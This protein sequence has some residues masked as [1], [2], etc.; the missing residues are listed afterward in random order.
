M[1]FNPIDFSP[2]HRLWALECR[3]RLEYAL[4]TAKLDADRTSGPIW[5]TPDEWLPCLLLAEGMCD[6]EKSE[7]ALL[8]DLQGP[9]KAALNEALSTLANW[10]FQLVRTAPACFEDQTARLVQL[11]AAQKACE[12]YN[13]FRKYQPQKCLGV[14]LESMLLSGQSSSIRVAVDL[15]VDAPPTDWK[16]SA[17]A[18]GVLMQS[19][20]WKLA[21]VFP[22]LLDTNQPSV[23][24]PAL[25][26]ANNMA[27]KHGVRPHPAAERFDSLLTIF[28]AMTLQLQS[29]EENPRQFSDNVQVIQQILFDAVSLLV[30]LCDFFAQMGDPRSIGK[31]NQ[32]LV[33]KHRRLKL[34]SAYALAKLGE[35]RALDL[36]VELLQDDSSR[37]RAL[38]YLHELSADDRID[39]QWT[40]SL[41]KAKS[42]LAIWLSQPEQFAIPPSRIT[43][44]EQRTLQWPGFDGPQECFL[45][46]FD[47]GTGDGN[48]SNIGFSGPF[49]IAMSLDMKSF[50]NDTVFA[51]YLA[52]DIEDPHESRIAWDSLPEPHKDSY[53]PMLR[54]LEEKGLLGIK[55]LAQLNCLGAQALLCQATSD[56]GNAWGIL[57]DGDSI[58]RCISGPQTFETLFL[59]WKGKLALEILGES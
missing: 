30:A 36:I 3:A 38:A 14:L 26:L 58:I 7:Q 46:Q 4:D 20:N 25:D 21:D 19:T 41:A 31:L 27:R 15:L 33:L 2:E 1:E 9:G 10:L 54:E 34:E 23:L 40:S 42:D 45:L 50:S 52:N 56:E 55:P 47:Y 59:Q 32:A 8:K 51:M 6:L 24:A 53:E 16:D 13:A 35:S 49:P 43:L 28:G 17:Q 37:A 39:P 11:L 5:Q 18:L 48:Y 22:R 12:T 29:L 44:V 57:T